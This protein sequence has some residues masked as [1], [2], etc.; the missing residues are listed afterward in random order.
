MN[1]RDIGMNDLVDDNRFN[2]ISGAQPA[3]KSQ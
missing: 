3:Y 2:Q 1:I